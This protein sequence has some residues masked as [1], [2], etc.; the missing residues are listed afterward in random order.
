MIAKALLTEVRKAKGPIYV[1]AINF[2]DTYL[3]QVVKS[4]LIAMIQ[5]K[6]AE[7]DDTG[8]ELTESGVFSKAW[9]F[10]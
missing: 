3:V 1:E 4:D 6:F 8:F 10:V 9:D 7:D 2:N 5:E